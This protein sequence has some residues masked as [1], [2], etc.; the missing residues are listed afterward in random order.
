MNGKLIKDVF[1]ESDEIIIM[2]AIFIWGQEMG[3]H[4]EDIQ[5]HCT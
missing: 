2:V 5:I 4:L 1:K 3:I